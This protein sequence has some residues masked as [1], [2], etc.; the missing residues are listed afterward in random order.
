MQL[1]EAHFGQRVRVNFVGAGDHG[2]LGTIKKVE[3]G[4]CYIHV[5]WDERPQ[6]TVMF[7]PSDLDPVPDEPA[8]KQ[9]R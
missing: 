9:A 4:K 3:G 5:D 7:F 2:R 8:F 1:E 6:H